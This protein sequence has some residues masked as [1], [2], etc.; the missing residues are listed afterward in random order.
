MPVVS[1]LPSH[2]TRRHQHG[3]KIGCCRVCTCELKLNKK[4]F[5]TFFLV[6]YLNEERINFRSSFGISHNKMWAFENIR[7]AFR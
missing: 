6:I 3:I 7:V 4:I 1:N 5:A 2:H